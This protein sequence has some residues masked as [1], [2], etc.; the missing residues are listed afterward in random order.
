MADALIRMEAATARA[1]DGRYSR[2]T[3]A[4]LTARAF[5]TPL[6]NYLVNTPLFL[7]PERINLKPKHRV[8]EVGCGEGA[9]LR[10][11]SARIA[12][13]RRPLGIDLSGAALRRGAS[14]SDAYG[15]VQ[16]SAARLPLAS[17]SVDLVL[18]AHLIRFLPPEGFMRFVLEAE[19]VLRPGGLLAVWDVAPSSSGRLNRWNAGVLRW[20]GGGGEPRGFAQL[21]H[22]MAEMGCW[23]VI[24][25]FD[26][27]PFLAPP[28]PRTGMICKKAGGR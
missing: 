19:R 18:A 4:G 25:R 6:G 5:E 21:A 10:F 3:A 14:A 22:D 2:P 8:V 27:R 13:E 11:L 12:F 20:F 17:A 23:S 24:E 26:L 28:I 15:V 16:G 7:L 1:V 9:N